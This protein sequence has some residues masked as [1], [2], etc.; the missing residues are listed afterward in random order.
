VV[1]AARDDKATARKVNGGAAMSERHGKN[2]EIDPSRIV[3]ETPPH[4]RQIDPE[5]ARRLGRLP[6]RAQVEPPPDPRAGKLGQTA[7]RTQVEPPDQTARVQRAQSEAGRLA[8]RNAQ[9]EDR[10]SRRD[11]PTSPERHERD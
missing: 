1:T 3:G 10:T 5:R 9:R 7:T 4:D 8:V 2:P 6:T 11:R